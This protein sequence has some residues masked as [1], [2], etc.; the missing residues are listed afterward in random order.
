MKKLMQFLVALSVAALF[1][2]AAAAATIDQTDGA[3]E[4]G[5][6]SLGKVHVVSVA[7]EAPIASSNTYVLAELPVGAYVLGAGAHAVGLSS[8]NAT[9]NIYNGTSG[10]TCA[11]S[12]TINLAVNSTGT[13]AFEWE[14]GAVT[15]STEF[16]GIKVSANQ[17]AGTVWLDLLVMQP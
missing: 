3:S 6:P 5:G 8:T 14:G 2:G 15:D 13:P 9:V 4:L 10:T 12:V 17:T 1:A 16:Y 7:L 11:T